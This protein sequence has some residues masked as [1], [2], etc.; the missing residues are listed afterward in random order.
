MSKSST[1]TAK[2]NKEKKNKNLDGSKNS[3]GPLSTYDFTNFKIDFVATKEILKK[4]CKKWVFQLEECP[5]TKTN[6]YQGRFSLKIKERMTTV[7][8]KFPGWHISITSL[9]NIKNDFYVTKEESKIDGPWRDDDEEI[10][11][12]RQVRDMKN[13]FPWQQKV[14]ESKNIYDPRTIDCIY[15]ETGEVG[16]SSLVSYVRVYKIGRPIPICFE[17]KDVMR[18]VLNTYSP[19]TCSLFLIDIPRALKGKELNIFF[20]GIEEIKN[21]YCYDDRYKWREQDFDRPRIWVFTNTLPDFS[22]LSADKWKLWQV[23]NGELVD[24]VIKPNIELVA[25]FE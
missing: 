6:H 4:F 12:P 15:D 1:K 2:N 23:I 24:Y 18:M 16:K 20:G 14:V 11:I 22:L 25:D 10:Y 8:K 7:F 17:Y 5:K 21:G 3:N 13:L 9:E 19:L